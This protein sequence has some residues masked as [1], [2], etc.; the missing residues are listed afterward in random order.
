M[1]IRDFLAILVV[2]LAIVVF[3]VIAFLFLIELFF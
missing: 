3:A 2:G 1:K